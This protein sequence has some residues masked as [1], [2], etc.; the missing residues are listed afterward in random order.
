LDDNG[1]LLIGLFQSLRL[2]VGLHS[3]GVP[4]ATH[5][6]DRFPNFFVRSHIQ[7]SFEFTGK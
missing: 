6:V 3:G 1:D 7:H 4:R 2:S 5:G